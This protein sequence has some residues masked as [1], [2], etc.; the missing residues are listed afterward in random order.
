MSQRLD[1]IRAFDPVEDSHAGWLVELVTSMGNK[2]GNN[3]LLGRAYRESDLCR[4][5]KQVIRW[6]LDHLSSLDLEEEPWH[7]RAKILC[8]MAG[9]LVPQ[10]LLLC[11]MLTSCRVVQA[12]GARRFKH[13]C[14]IGAG[15]AM[16]VQVTLKIAHKSRSRP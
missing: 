16:Y 15:M 12:Y 13:H 1:A 8:T 3:A 14:Q 10:Y 6:L 11:C 9:T 5:N 7:S 2:P 4:I